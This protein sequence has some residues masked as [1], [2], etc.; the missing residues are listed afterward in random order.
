MKYN[1]IIVSI[2]AVM[3]L[4]GCEGGDADSSPSVHSTGASTSAGA[5]VPSNGQSV[6]S[7]STSTSAATTKTSASTAIH[8]SMTAGAPL[9]GGSTAGQIPDINLDGSKK[10]DTDAGGEIPSTF[11]GFGAV[12]GGGGNS[13][14]LMDYPKQQRDEI[15]DYLF[16]PNY[17]AALQI[18]K[19][20]I[21]GDTNT[22]SGAEPSFEHAKNI[23]N[24]SVGYE[25][26]LM[27]EA[28]KRNPKIKF[29]ALTWGAPG[30]IM[31]GKA[32]PMRD[33]KF[34]ADYFWTDSS[35]QYVI[36][37]LNLAR[38][39]GTPISYLGGLNE[40]GYQI[41]WYKKLR[42]NLNSNGFS[43]VKII[44]DDGTLTK[45]WKVAGDVAAD[46][47]F[48]SVVDIIGVHYECGYINDDD[49]AHY[50]NPSS[51]A[52][53]T[54]KTLWQSE[55]GSQGY[56]ADTG[57]AAMLRGSI[58]GYID[59]RFTGNI[60]WPVVASA[61]PTVAFS[62]AGFILANEPWTGNYTIGNN[63]WTA[64][65]VTQFVQPG[66]RYLRNG[67]G[68]IN[69]D[70]DIG[71]YM[72]LIAPDGSD[73]SIILET[74]DS[75]SAQTLHFKTLNLPRKPLHVWESNMK[76]RNSK[77]F[78][79]RGPDI[80]P[81]GDGFSITLQPGMA[82]SL[83][84]TTG[85]SHGSPGTIVPGSSILAIPYIDDMGGYKVGGEARYLSD[86]QGSFEIQ[87]CQGGIAGN[88]IQQMAPMKPLF[89]NGAGGSSNPFAIFGDARW[90]DYSISDR[91]FF[92]KPGMLKL[93]GRISKIPKEGGVPYGYAFLVYDNGKWSLTK[94]SSGEPVVISSG[95]VHALDITKWHDMS[96]MM[97]GDNIAIS[98]DGQILKVDKDTNPLL[99]GMAGIGTDNYNLDQF[100]HLRICPVSH[101]SMPPKHVEDCKLP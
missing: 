30:W 64:A 44:A 41:D 92:S 36:D 51:I 9:L 86:M 27:S 4:T 67:S 42:E 14:L 97:N 38:K 101:A 49:T 59:A 48:A 76:S 20:E 73:Y 79:V 2:I 1:V 28:K 85:Q 6:A 82:Y 13:R 57:M 84:T 77:D 87:P 93:F 47:T 61:Y 46:P 100:S 35:I 89:W 83:T 88:C 10:A 74:Y 53:G 65:H 80:T 99:S 58:R 71:S 11:D 96:I 5:S 98:L 63:L 91:V 24:E 15:L 90:S 17:G 29:G 72:S 50:C 55:S 19:V 54:R 68:Y 32:P 40:S 22:T 95:S 70:R 75:S 34:D 7:E 39:N 26:W 16:K 43:D 21:G 66:W 31:E 56:N 18:L 62:N 60:N 69:G 45:P 94:N 25:L 12:S 3:C 78:M 52:L 37:Y 33:P 23:I 8:D 81:T